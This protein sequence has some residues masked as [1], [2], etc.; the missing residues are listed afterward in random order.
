MTLADEYAFS[1]VVDVVVDVEISI[2]GSVG[3]SCFD[4][5]IQLGHRYRDKKFF[6]FYS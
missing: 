6:L 3:N 1:R 4:G 2:E 5:S